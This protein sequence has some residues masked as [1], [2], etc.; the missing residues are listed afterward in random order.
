[1]TLFSS[2]HIVRELEVKYKGR[3]K[4]CPRIQSGSDASKFLHAVLPEGPIEKMVCLSLGSK[5]Q[6]VGWS[7]VGVG[8]VSNCPVDPTTVLRFVLLSGGISFILAHN[9]PSGDLQPSKEDIDLTLRLRDAAR[10]VGLQ[11][12]DHLILGDRGQFTCLAEAE[13]V[14]L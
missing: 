7:L 5:N 13:G 3:G 9:H 1:M 10:L 6:P 12:L 8:G 11:L 2:G 14:D 4:A